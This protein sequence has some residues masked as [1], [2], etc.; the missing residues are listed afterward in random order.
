MET[1]PVWFNSPDISCRDVEVG[2]MYPDEENPDQ[3][4]VAKNVCDT[5]FAQQVCLDWAMNHREGI[6]VYG[7]LTGDERRKL[8]NKLNRVHN[9]RRTE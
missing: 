5:C 8:Q 6:G 1:L 3:V 7:G 9:G 2:T 4:A